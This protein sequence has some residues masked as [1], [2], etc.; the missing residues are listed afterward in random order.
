MPGTY[1]SLQPEKET[2]LPVIW[3]IDIWVEMDAI[4]EDPPS[5]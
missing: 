5:V 1:I 2:D 4:I 3:Q